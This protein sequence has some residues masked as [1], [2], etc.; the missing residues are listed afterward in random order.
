MGAYLL[1]PLIFIGIYD[2]LL[3]STFDKFIEIIWARLRNMT[4][5]EA[6]RVLAEANLGADENL[7][8]AAMTEVTAQNSYLM[9]RA[10]TVIGTVRCHSGR[11]AAIRSFAETAL[12]NKKDHH[13]AFLPRNLL[14]GIALADLL[15]MTE[16]PAMA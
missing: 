8:D 2:T 12:E 11:L 13:R 5:V 16:A 3:F 14:A 9:Q 6:A 7:A 10:A 15:E 4:R 1:S